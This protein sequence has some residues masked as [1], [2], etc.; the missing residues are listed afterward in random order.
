MIKAIIVDD[1]E[2]DDVKIPQK[3]QKKMKRIH[4]PDAIISPFHNRY[5]KNNEQNNEQTNPITTITSTKKCK[6][7]K[8][9][10]KKCE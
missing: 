5:N 7:K 4:I 8:Y 10:S 1:D 3:S 2:P 6:S 9:K